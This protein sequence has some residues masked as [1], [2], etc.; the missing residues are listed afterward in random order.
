MKRFVLLAAVLSLSATATAAQGRP[1]TTAMSCRQAAG[2]VASRGAVVLSTGQPDLYD[3]FVRDQ[4]YCTRERTTQPAYEPTA[5]SPSCFIGYRCIQ[6]EPRNGI[7]PP[8]PR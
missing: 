2:L 1:D 5:D 4:S 6:D 8:F 7:A 3:R